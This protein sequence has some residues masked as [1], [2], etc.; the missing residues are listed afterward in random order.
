[1]F[2]PVL[3]LVVALGLGSVVAENE[4]LAHLNIVTDQPSYDSVGLNNPMMESNGEKLVLSTLLE[5]DVVFD[6]GANIG[7]WSMAVLSDHPKI[8]LYA[9]E[10]IPEL[11]AIVKQRL[12]DRVANYLFSLS[13]RLGTASFAYYP[14]CAA[15]STLH[16]RYEVEKAHGMAPLLLTVPLETLDHF[17]SEHKIPRINFLKIDTEGNERNVLLGAKK[18]L[19]KK[20]VDI[21]QFEYGGTYLDSKTTLHQVY[22]YLQRHGYTIYRIASFGLIEIPRWRQA[23][24]NYAYSNYLAVK[25]P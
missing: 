19:E 4:R 17:T 24:E 9:F 3:F 7:D 13:D 12:G 5:G 10:P 1:M 25:K 20:A 6:V 16:R 21:I 23:L 15:F 11:S 18:L 22:N 8:A 14:S 2:N